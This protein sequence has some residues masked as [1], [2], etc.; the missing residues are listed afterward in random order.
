M[1]GSTPSRVP[2]GK[3]SGLRASEVRAVRLPP[4]PDGLRREVLVLRDADGALRG[5]DGGQVPLAEQH[6]LGRREHDVRRG[7]R[8]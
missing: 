4:T 3:L 1:S 8:V 2:A 6:A 7:R 5:D